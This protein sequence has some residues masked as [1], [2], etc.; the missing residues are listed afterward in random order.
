MLR[1]GRHEAAR[2]REV[3]VGVWRQAD[4]I[5]RRPRK[6][7]HRVKVGPEPVSDL[8]PAETDM[9]AAVRQ[10]REELPNL[11]GEKKMSAVARGVQPQHRT[12][13]MRRRQ[14]VQHRKDRRHPDSGADERHG[15]LAGLQEERP[16]RRADFEKIPHPHVVSHIGTPYAVRFDL[17]ADPIAIR[18]GRS[19]KRVA[20]KSGRSPTLGRKRSTTYWLGSASGNGSSWSRCIVSDTTSAD[21]WSIAVNFSGPNPD[22]LRCRRRVGLHPL[23]NV[24]HQAQRGGNATARPVRRSPLHTAP[25]GIA[26]ESTRLCQGFC[27]A[28]PG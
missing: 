2:A 19:R 23:D 6:T 14:G 20:A 26:R 5:E 3:N 16:A 28:P 15:P 9:A 1:Q 17:H 25:P 18:R 12:R 8:P 4:F 10:A 11:G 21:S 22:V 27:R 7:A 13:R 24:R